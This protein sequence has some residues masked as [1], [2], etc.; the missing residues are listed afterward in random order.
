MSTET[1]CKCI[2]RQEV[3][4]IVLVFCQ[5]QKQFVCCLTY[6]SMKDCDIKMNI[7]GPLGVPCLDT[8]GLHQQYSFLH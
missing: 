2:L 5:N 8:M 4:I 6:V 7:F 1:V 3:A